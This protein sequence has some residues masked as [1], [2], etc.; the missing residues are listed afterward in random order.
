LRMSPLAER[1]APVPDVYLSNF[2]A[3][4]RNL[5]LESGE[6]MFLADLHDAI[7][8]FVRM[9]LKDA[10]MGN[11]VLVFTFSADGDQAQ[12]GNEFHQYLLELS[13]GQRVLIGL[14]S[15]LHFALRPGAT[16]LFDEPDN[17]IAL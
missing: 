15:V 16:V 8:G 14:Y 12:P 3:W 13:D 17:F 2:A 9:D 10:G 6:Q 1:E 5:R 4:Y 7:P 11:R